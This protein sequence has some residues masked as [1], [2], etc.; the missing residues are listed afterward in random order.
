M[1]KKKVIIFY[2]TKIKSICFVFFRK[3]KKMN[4]SSVSK[5][6]FF[7]IPKPNFKPSLQLKEIF[8]GVVVKIGTSYNEKDKKEEIQYINEL[9]IW[10]QK[11]LNETK[12]VQTELLGR[13]VQK[14]ENEYAE[15][16]KH[17]NE[18]INNNFIQNVN[19]YFPLQE[20]FAWLWNTEENEKSVGEA[21]RECA[22]HNSTY[23]FFFLA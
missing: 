15:I 13:F 2:I 17:V 6:V 19:S 12:M 10:V 11:I 4:Q 21:K 16:V 14:Q 23:S 8:P 9:K 18:T 3:K 20:D 5:R 7:S 22:L 1:K